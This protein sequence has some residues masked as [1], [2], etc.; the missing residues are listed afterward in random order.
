MLIGIILGGIV[1][2]FLGML[3]VDIRHGRTW[4]VYTMENRA[5]GGR[6][7]LVEGRLEAV[8][9]ELDLMEPEEHG[10]GRR[11]RLWLQELEKQ[12]LTQEEKREWEAGM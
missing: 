11:R 5:L 12:E 8:E 10:K 6:L 2:M 7:K 3:W 1:G 4:A 9:R